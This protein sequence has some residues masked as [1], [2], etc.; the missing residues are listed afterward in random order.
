MNR[1]PLQPRVPEGYRLVYAQDF[2]S[3]LALDDFL[4]TDPEAWRYAT[5]NGSGCLELFRQSKYQPRV[6][7]PYNI[8]LVRGVWVRDFILEA[9]LMQT[10]REYGHRDM[11]LFLCVK[12]PTNFYYVHLASQADPH[13]H[14][15]FLVNDEPR[16]AIAKKTT[17]GIRWGQNQW[18]KVR[19]ER[20]S[21]TGV[22][23]VFFDDMD[24]P[25]M[26]AQDTHFDW[27]MIGFGSF[28]DTGR[29]RRIRL[30]AREVRPEPPAI[31]RSQ[32]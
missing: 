9:E 29:V 7:S 12:D 30:W 28:D 27:G 16:I 22:I 19:I 15:I 11:C 24:R 17:S 4:F 13:A 1:K 25:I 23:R 5:V 32:H 3:E 20:E 6:R 10:G 26:E 21:Q 18:H 2:T 14:N 8:A 31:F